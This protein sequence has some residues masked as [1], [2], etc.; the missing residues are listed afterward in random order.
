MIKILQIR[1]APLSKSDGL[2]ANCQGLIRLF[3]GDD[4]I[5]M[6]PTLNYTRHSDPILH[7]YWLD[8]K[9]IC[10]S[11]EEL[12]PDIVHI[13]GAYSFTLLV[14]VLCARKYNKS[15]VFSPHFH[16][17][18]S[19]RRPLLGKLFFYL[20][21]KHVLKHINL[22]YTINKEDTAIFS[23]YHKNVVCIP[24]W[25]KFHK[26]SS[27]VKKNPKMILFVGR[28][29]ESNK[30]F[31]HLFHLPEG[32]Y[33][34]HCVGKGSVKMRRDMIQH[35]DITDEKLNELYQKASLLVV[36]SRYEAFSYVTIEALM[37]NTPVVVSD[38]V[39]IA[40]HLKDISGYRV[41]KY[42]NYDDFVDAVN[43]T[44]GI[45]VDVDKVERI[46]NPITIKQI[47]KKSYLGL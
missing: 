23:K 14:S 44:L 8:K 17:F 22:I 41:F 12:N 18:Y 9:E 33:E 5:K 19:L 6:I 11:I 29:D 43:E 32:K 16:P 26:I 3:E 28:I 10:R 2:D 4:I 1:E 13:H 38:R 15:I 36:P 25:S 40:D 39:R 47:Y 30:G 21:T 46:F 20:I 7:Q 35:T 24:H 37:S 42:K 31:E 27:G 34:I 45:S